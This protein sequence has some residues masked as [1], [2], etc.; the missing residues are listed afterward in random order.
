M[1]REPFGQ[2]PGTMDKITTDRIKGNSTRAPGD[3]VFPSHSYTFKA[4][5]QNLFQAGAAIAEPYWEGKRMSEID[6]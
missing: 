3:K 2:N 6:Q 1:E 5:S 4:E